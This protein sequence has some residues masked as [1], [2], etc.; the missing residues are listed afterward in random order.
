MR[1]GFYSC[2]CVV[3]LLG[4]RVARAD[5]WGWIPEIRALEAERALSRV[6]LMQRAMLNAVGASMLVNVGTVLSVSAM[7][8]AAGAA[9]VGAG[10]CG[11]LTALAL[12]KLR[13]AESKEAQ[14]T[15]GS[16]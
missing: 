14:L 16:A 9:F 5:G 7:G 11:V 10:A 4:A 2:C 15:G 6:A 12:F 3:L 8:A 1:F 13:L